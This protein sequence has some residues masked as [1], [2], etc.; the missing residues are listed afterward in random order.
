MGIMNTPPVLADL[1]T[2]RLQQISDRA[3]DAALALFEASEQY[4]AR[5]T[6]LPVRAPAYQALSAEASALLTAGREQHRL[7]TET[8]AIIRA[9]VQHAQ[10][11]ARRDE[12]IREWQPGID[13]MT[14]A[15]LNED[16]K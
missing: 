10:V 15:I 12:L 1:P 7:Y 11:T 3:Y 5:M 8:T 16:G 13:A 6:Q 2:A 9:R 4:Y 14:E